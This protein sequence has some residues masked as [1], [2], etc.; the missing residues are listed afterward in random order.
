MR[1]KVRGILHYG[2]TLNLSMPSPG[3]TFIDIREGLG[4]ELCQAF[5]DRPTHLEVSSRSHGEATG[6]IEHVSRQC[7][8]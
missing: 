5:A 6:K 1:S 3:T 8:S 4:S 2:R 7:P